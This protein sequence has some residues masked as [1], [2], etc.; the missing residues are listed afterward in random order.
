MSV[1]PLV[2]FIPSHALAEKGIV[3][4]QGGGPTGDFG[5]ILLSESCMK[6]GRFGCVWFVVHEARAGLGA[7]DIHVFSSH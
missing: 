2:L 4:A 3:W 5:A 7:V 6:R 1:S